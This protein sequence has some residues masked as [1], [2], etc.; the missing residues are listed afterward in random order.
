MKREELIKK[1]F[2]PRQVI[3]REPEFD[4][5]SSCESLSNLGYPHLY[6]ISVFLPESIQENWLQTHQIR[7]PENCCVCAKPAETYLDS[8]VKKTWVGAKPQPC[9]VNIPHCAAHGE[10]EHALLVTLCDKY[11]KSVMRL[12]L[13]G[14]NK[15]FLLQTMEQNSQGDAVPPWRAFP[16]LESVSSGWR[17]GDSQFWLHRYFLPFWEKLNLSEKSAYLDRWQADELWREQIDAWNN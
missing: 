10:K 3:S 13:I 17:Q 5:D 1:V 15:E 8:Y 7:F 12:T 14:V 16:E 4:E 11:S 2:G 6:Q 9:V